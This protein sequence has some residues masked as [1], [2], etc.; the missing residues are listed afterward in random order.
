MAKRRIRKITK[1]RPNKTTALIVVC[2]AIGFVVAALPT[3]TVLCVG[4]IPTVVAYIVDLTPGRYCTRCV[5]GVNVA[6]VIPFLDRLWT[7]S[8]DLYSAIG[9]VT[10]VFAW[11]AFYVAAGIGW[12]LF[13]CLPAIVASFNTYNAQRR[14]NKLR[15]RLEEL[16]REWGGEVTGN[17]ADVVQEALAGDLADAAGTAKAASNA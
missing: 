13:L 4:M 12:V 16:K 3:V 7:S 9:I 17:P 6:G 8:N 1:R 2:A 5:A 14:T 11:L 15:E 10:D